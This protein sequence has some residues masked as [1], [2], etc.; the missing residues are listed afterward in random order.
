MITAEDEFI[1]KRYIEEM[2]PL[3]V[4]E[5]NESSCLVK[6]AGQPVQS[7]GANVGRNKNLE[8]ARECHSPQP[9]VNL[10]KLLRSL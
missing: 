6:P 7:E 1:S 2:N 10:I 3:E 4:K 9:S 8:T 5:H